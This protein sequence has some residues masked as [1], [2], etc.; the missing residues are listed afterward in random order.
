MKLYRITIGDKIIE[1]VKTYEWDFYG[2]D[3]NGKCS[4]TFVCIRGCLENGKRY[5]I[6]S[7]YHHPIIVE[8]L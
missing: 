3:F 1:P 6:I 7:S 8:E 4:D 2:G 5:E